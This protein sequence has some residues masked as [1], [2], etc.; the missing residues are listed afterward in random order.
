MSGIAA[1]LHLWQCL[2]IYASFWIVMYRSHNQTTQELV[3]SFANR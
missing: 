2:A 3:V 1:N